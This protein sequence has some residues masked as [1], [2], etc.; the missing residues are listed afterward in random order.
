MMRQSPKNWCLRGWTGAVLLAATLT[1]GCMHHPGGI[2]PSTKPLAPGGYTELG[3]VRGPNPGG[4]VAEDIG[5]ALGLPVLAAVGADKNLDRRME[6]GEA[7]GARSR[8]PLGRAGDG[9][10]REILA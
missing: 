8:S 6:R 9:L 1:A 5:T 3:K 4:L 7:P 2:A 10:L